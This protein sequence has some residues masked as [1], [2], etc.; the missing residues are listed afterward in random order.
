MATEF[1]LPELGENI[2]SGDVLRVLVKPGDVIERDQPVLELETDKATLEV[3]SAVAGRVQTVNVNEGDQVQVGQAVLTVEDSQQTGNGNQEPG[4]GKQETGDGNQETGLPRRSSPE[5]SEGG[6][7]PAAAAPGAEA[8]AAGGVVEVKIPELGENV[9]SGDVLRLLVKP[10]DVVEREQPVI[11]LETEKATVEVPSSAAGR[12][13]EIP[14]KEGETVKVGQVIFT[15]DVSG[16]GAAAAPSAGKAQPPD[17][18]SEAAPGAESPEWA[19]EAERPRAEV[20]DISRV[21]R[22]APSRAEPSPPG[23]AEAIPPRPNVPAAPSIRRLARELGVDVRDVPGSGPAGRISRADV[24]AHAKEIITSAPLPAMQPGAVAAP[25]LPDFAKWGEIDR[26][27]MSGVRRKTAEHLSQAWSLIPSVTQSERA[28]IT[29][30]ED[31]R[32]RFAPQVEQASGKLTVTAILAKILAAAVKA[33]PQFNTSLDSAQEELIYK[34]YVHVGIAVD[35]ERGLLVPVIR[36]VDAK[37]ITQ[38]AVEIAQA[39]QRARDRKLT[40][41]EM[42]GGSITITNLGGLG[43]THF[44]PIVNWPEVAILGVSRARMEPVWIDAAFQPRL[45]LPLSLS[46]DHRVIDG[47]DAMR[48]L[49]WVADALEQPFLL[50]LQG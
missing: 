31:L 9:T 47:A 27:T 19:P 23:R 26:K 39:A 13:R 20:Y 7:A 21:V 46:Y 42:E 43:G 16:P 44:S 3:P 25:A 36:D 11:E 10:G 8:A 6:P 12:V 30:L 41:A 22:Q 37:N 4:T 49:R 40:M 15:L 14:V 2:T 17:A 33:F 35:T 28:D 45:M 1:A 5:A 50:A 34:K 29:A 24:L 18:A 32:K 38:I 48:F